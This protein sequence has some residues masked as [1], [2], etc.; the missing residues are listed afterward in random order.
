[1]NC[2]YRQQKKCSFEAFKDEMRFWNA[3]STRDNFYYHTE[4]YKNILPMVYKSLA[5]FPAEISNEQLSSVFFL[6]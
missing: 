5:R 2:Y 1:M 3:S 4:L 6:I